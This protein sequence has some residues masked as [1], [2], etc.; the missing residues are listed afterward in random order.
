MKV[1]AHSK[2]YQLRT[3]IKPVSDKLLMNLWQE[4]VKTRADYVCEYPGC[5]KDKYLNAHHIHSRSKKS[6]KF[7]PDNG[8]CLCPFHHSLGNDSAHKSPDF[9]DI[10]IKAGV[11]T[12]EFYK[13]L[14]TRANNTAKLDKNLIL[15]DL[16]NELNKLKEKL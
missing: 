10:I 1:K 13:M 5:N 4:I 8:M 7:D 9:K 11:R 3:L 16:R 15:L 2:K 6:V 14:T 12:K